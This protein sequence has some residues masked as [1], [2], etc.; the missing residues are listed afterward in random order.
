MSADDQKRVEMALRERERELSLLVDMTPSHLWRLSPDGEPVFFNKRMV[1]FIG[2]D[3]AATIQPGKT[4][5]DVVIEATIHPEDAA[6]FGDTLRR[7]LASGDRFVMR[8][9]LRRADGVYR[10]MSSRAEPLRDEHGHIVQ[11][12]GLCHD[13]DDQVRAEDALRRSENQLRRMVDALPVRAFSTTPTG[14]QTYFNK[15]Y[16]DYLRTIIPNFD[17]LEE[18]LIS[19]LVADLLHPEDAPKVQNEVRRCFAT[20]DTFL[21]RYR[22][23]DQNGVYRWA[24]G[25]MEP[26]RDQDGTIVQWYAINLDVDDEVQAAEALRRA[27]DQLAQATRA[28]SLAEL[29]ASVAHEVNQPLAAIVTNSQACHRWLSADPPNVERAKT[30]A[31]RI[32]LRGRQPPD[33]RGL[34]PRGG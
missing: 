26:E 3:L 15:R 10:W 8:Y 1:D 4:R 11:W 16:E 20:G 18:P 34:S 23:R 33:Q 19:R 25:R 6:R 28:A 32:T 29:S 2:L 30:I 31:E 21:M 7:C 9:R 14:Q 12:Y 5:L 17:E 13:I 24:E 27:S 22:R